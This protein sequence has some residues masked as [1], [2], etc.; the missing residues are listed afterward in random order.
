MSQLLGI[1][2]LAGPLLLVVAPLLILLQFFMRLDQK[3]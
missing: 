2:G 1:L 3:N